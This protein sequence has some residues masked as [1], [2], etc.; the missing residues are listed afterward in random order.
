MLQCCNAAAIVVL[1]RFC[2][3]CH[4]SAVVVSVDV[5]G[6]PMQWWCNA[7][8]MLMQYWC[9]ANAMPMQYQCSADI[10]P[11]QCQCNANAMSMHCLRNANAMLML[12]LQCWFSAATATPLLVQCCCWWRWRTTLSK[13]EANVYSDINRDYYCM[14]WVYECIQYMYI[15]MARLDI[16]SVY[17]CRGLRYR[18]FWQHFWKSCIWV[19][20]VGYLGY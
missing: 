17:L 3:C 2:W 20:L 8:V 6:I 11:M 16:G 4:C 19:T 10:M 9:K 18:T 15:V 1:L 13:K 14:W 7:N 12:L 5:D